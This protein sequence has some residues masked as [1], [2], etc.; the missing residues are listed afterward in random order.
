M[1]RN[2]TKFVT[3]DVRCRVWFKEGNGRDLLGKMGPNTSKRISMCHWNVSQMVLGCIRMFTFFGICKMHPNA[4]GNGKKKKNIENAVGCILFSIPFERVSVKVL[5]KTVTKCSRSLLTVECVS[6]AEF[7]MYGNPK[8]NI[9][10]CL[11]FIFLKI[12]VANTKLWKY[13]N[14]EECNLTFQRKCFSCSKAWGD[15]NPIFRALPVILQFSRLFHWISFWILCLERNE[16]SH[17]FLG[18]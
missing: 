16:N 3:I 9:L 4:N 18:N 1:L 12:V 8:E 17:H 15:F 5:E 14:N 6:I 13:L 11:A 7:C 2:I 10:K